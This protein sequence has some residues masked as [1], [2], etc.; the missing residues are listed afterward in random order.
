MCPGATF[1]A[2]ISKGFHAGDIVWPHLGSVGGKFLPRCPKGT[3][4]PSLAPWGQ[5]FC[6]VVPQALFGRFFTL[7]GSVGANFLPRCPTGTFWLLRQRF[8]KGP[9]QDLAK[10]C[11]FLKATLKE[12]ERFFFLADWLV[13]L[14]LVRHSLAPWGQIFCPV[15]PQAHFYPPWLR[16]GNFFA[17]LS[18]R[19]FWAGFFYNP[20]D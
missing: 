6:P 1:G 15:V 13:S 10:M 17:P 5:M 18:H 11:C 8:G 14:P 9:T 3:F 12:S 2:R 20:S 7:L 16:G 4:S 19:H